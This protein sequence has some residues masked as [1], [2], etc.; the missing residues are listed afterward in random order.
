MNKKSNWK[1]ERASVHHAGAKRAKSNKYTK[2]DSHPRPA[3]HSRSKVWIGAY[4]RRDGIR[5][6]GH[7]RKVNV[8]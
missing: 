5:V 8:K 7:F 4:T 1:L 6:E 3:P 2:S